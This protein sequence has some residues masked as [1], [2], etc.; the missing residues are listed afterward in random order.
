MYIRI[1]RSGKM[2]FLQTVASEKEEIKKSSDYNFSVSF[3]PL[4]GVSSISWEQREVN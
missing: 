4:P 2:D 3:K 1:N